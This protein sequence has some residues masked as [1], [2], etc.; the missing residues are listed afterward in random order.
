ML[1][2]ES[3]NRPIMDEDLLRVEQA[4]GRPL[5]EQ[6]GAFLLAHNGGRPQPNLIDIEDAHFGGADI[7]VFH[8]L[9][10]QIE[11][12]DLMWNLDILEGCK[13]NHLLPIACDSFGNI[14]MLVL[15]ENDYGHVLY[16]DSAEVPP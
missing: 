8:G 10:T 1:Q 5:P 6:Y 16:F 14:F 11:S 2:I 3:D 12:S 13:E 15:A 9:D 4:I 7:Q